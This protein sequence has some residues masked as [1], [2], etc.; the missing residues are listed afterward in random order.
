MIEV[1][2]VNSHEKAGRD[3]GGV[4]NTR[5]MPSI[6]SSTE[7]LMGKYKASTSSGSTGTRE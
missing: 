3:E 1:S 2:F 5:P 4:P 6:C 7:P